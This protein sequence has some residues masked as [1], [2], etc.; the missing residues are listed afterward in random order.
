MRKRPS[1]RCICDDPKISSVADVRRFAK[2]LGMCTYCGDR[3]LELIPFGQGRYHVR[4]FL[5]R[6]GML[7]LVT[8][9]C[10]N[11]ARLCCLGKKRMRRLLDLLK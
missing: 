3:G 8:T 6:F 4:C 2:T 5:R 10:V 11:R 1:G 9:D 7:V